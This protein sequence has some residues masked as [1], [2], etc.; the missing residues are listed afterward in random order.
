MLSTV[1]P[2]SQP[3]FP[4]V[5]R[6]PQNLSVHVE[7][8]P[9][10]FVRFLPD[11]ALRGLGVTACW[12]LGG[13]PCGLAVWGKTRGLSGARRMEGEGQVTVKRVGRGVRLGRLR[14]S[15]GRQD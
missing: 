10:A 12:T 8:F 4:G 9:L 2:H 6:L 14:V 13:I 11:G 15:L 7:I 3:E 1:I 5:A